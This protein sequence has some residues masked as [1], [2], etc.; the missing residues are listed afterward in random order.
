MKK[1]S[2][3]RNERA[4]RKKDIMILPLIPPFES[5]VF[6]DGG[7]H[8]TR[9][10]YNDTRPL[11]DSNN[12]KFPSYGSVEAR[13]LNNLLKSR[14]THRCFDDNTHTYRL[15][16]FIGTLRD[17]GWTI[18]NHDEVAQTNDFVPR[19]VKYT[20]YELYADFTP[21]LKERINAFIKSVDAFEARF[22]KGKVQ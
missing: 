12:I 5:K 20:R 16:S 4:T 8:I 18:V 22:S 14:I 10:D 9:A 13:C 19:K 2:E 21:E 15:S 1:I 11:L 17:K 7:K 3:A 6:R